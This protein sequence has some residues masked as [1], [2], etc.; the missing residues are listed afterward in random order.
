MKMMKRLMELPQGTLIIHGAAEGAD[1]MADK[2]SR[3]LG[4][5]I[6]RYPLYK[7]DW[8]R[9]GKEAGNLR[10]QR[11]LNENEVDLVLCF[12]TDYNESKGTKDMLRRAH[13]DGVSWEIIE[14]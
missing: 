9:E 3:L 6:K 1:K 7:D 5:D 2:I 13:V 4:F 12:F 14:K 10:N 11:M 8:R